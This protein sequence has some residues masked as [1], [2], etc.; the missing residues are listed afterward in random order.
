[1]IIIEVFSYSTNKHVIIMWY[2]QNHLIHIHSVINHLL[3]FFATATHNSFKNNRLN[4]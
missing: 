4:V 3:L 1:M 2:Y